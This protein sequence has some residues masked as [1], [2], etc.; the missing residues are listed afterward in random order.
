LNRLLTPL[1]LIFGIILLLPVQCTFAYRWTPGGVHLELIPALLLY[2]AFTVNVP[3]ALLLA[4]V[5]SIMYDSYSAG[6]FGSSVIPYI[7]TV[8]L[9]CAVRPIFFR[10]RI[11]TQFASGFVFCFI[12]VTLQWVLSGKFG[13]GFQAIVPKITNLAL[14]TGALA[15][16]YFRILDFFCHFMGLNPGRFEEHAT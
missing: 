11:T 5:A 15:I 7:L 2:A 3:T 6:P 13:V 16:V 9:F 10:N 8:S 4:V 12:A 14:L 1:L